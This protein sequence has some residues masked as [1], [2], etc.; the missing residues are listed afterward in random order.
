MLQLTEKPFQNRKE[1]GERLAEE[2][3]R[4]SWPGDT[5]VAGLPRG[6]VVVAHQVAKKLNRPLEVA[7]VRKLGMVGQEELAMGAISGS[8]TLVNEAL[9]KEANLPKEKVEEVIRKERRELARQERLYRGDRPAPS[10]HGKPVIV[11]DDGLATGLTML[12]AVTALRSKRPGRLVAAVPVAA[13]ETY[14]DIRKV[15]DE[16]VCLVVPETLHAVGLWYD[17]FSPVS[18]Q[19]VQEL[20]KR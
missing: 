18:D 4:Y 17:D 1:A 9:I 20:L 14:E 2:L 7:V 15:V 13:R 11:V 6:G 19:D 16:M 8:V 5:V 12:A 3:N 10:I